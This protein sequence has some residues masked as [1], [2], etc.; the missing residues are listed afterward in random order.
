MRDRRRSRGFTLI[1]MA[2]VLVIIGTLVGA[3]SLFAVNFLQQQRQR[4]VQ[5]GLDAVEEALALH[6]ARHRRL[7]C[8]ASATAGTGRADAVLDG[9]GRVTAC[10]DDQQTGILPWVDLGLTQAQAIDPWGRFYTYR[11]AEDLAMHRGL[12]MIGCD[13]GA[14]AD[15]G[16]TP[17]VCT[18]PAAPCPCRGVDD[19]LVDYDFLADET[20][21]GAYLR[22][23]GL[24]IR[25][26]PSTADDG[27]LLLDPA[28]G[29]G[30]AYVVIGHGANGYGAFTASGQ[31]VAQSL[32]RS[33]TSP[34]N[35]TPN[36]NNSPLAAFYV[37]AP[38]R[39][40]E[41]DP[42]YFDDE[43][44]RPTILSVASRAGLGPRPGS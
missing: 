27:N 18:L 9:A 38:Q 6:V 42:L 40:G 11:V 33:P 17:P 37:D 5:G 3:G 22:D 1:E 29:T 19:D 12:T 30:A 36:A 21:V 35:E 28:A 4:D 23:L 16:D 44:R 39:Q 10:A 31:Y 7:P 25:S 26:D 15:I 32:G 20:E 14:D 8:P 34:A 41:T 43:I 13:P 2:I 24:A